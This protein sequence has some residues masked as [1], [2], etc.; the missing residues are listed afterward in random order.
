MH[1]C[2]AMFWHAWMQ[3]DVRHFGDSRR[4]GVDDRAVRKFFEAISG[5]TGKFN[6]LIRGV[7][8]QAI[9]RLQIKRGVSESASG[10]HSLASISSRSSDHLSGRHG[11]A[12][13]ADDSGSEMDES[14][15]GRGWGNLPPGPFAVA[16]ANSEATNGS[17]AGH[18]MA[19][20]RYDP[21]P[22]APEDLV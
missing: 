1:E 5:G 20:L 12:V 17:A 11:A 2:K 16:S 4:C 19:V 3:V 10:F 9:E 13:V 21:R 18:A 8:E 15:S 22:N 14:K 7:A 6:T